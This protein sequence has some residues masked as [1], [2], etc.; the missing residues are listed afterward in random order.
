L[1]EAEPWGEEARAAALDGVFTAERRALGVDDG[2][3]GATEA[4]ADEE[5]EEDGEEGEPTG[6]ESDDGL[7]F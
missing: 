2:P 6:S 1:E 7:C 3:G 4:A 5:E